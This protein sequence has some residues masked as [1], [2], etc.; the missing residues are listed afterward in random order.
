MKNIFQVLYDLKRKPELYLGALNL[1]YLYFFIN[2]YLFRISDTSDSCSEKIREL[3]FWLPNKTGIENENWLQNLL[4]AANYNEEE[5]LKLFFH[6][7]DIFLKE[8]HPECLDW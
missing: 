6:Y 2:G 5:A 1:T 7:L 8:E 4:L 3:H